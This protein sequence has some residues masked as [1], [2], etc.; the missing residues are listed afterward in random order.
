MRIGDAAH[1]A[2]SRNGL[3]G[4]RCVRAISDRD[5]HRPARE[6]WTTCLWPGR[7]AHQHR[8]HERPGTYPIKVCRSEARIWRASTERRRPAGIAVELRVHERRE[9]LDEV[10]A[11]QQSVLSTA[12]DCVHS[13]ATLSNGHAAWC[14]A[15]VRVR[16]TEACHGFFMVRPRGVT[17]RYHGGYSG[18]PRWNHLLVDRCPFRHARRVATRVKMQSPFDE[19]RPRG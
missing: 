19:A 4:P 10:G 12:L 9:S 13:S 16:A 11:R 14:Y 1:H 8:R 6:W 5:R 3:G 18:G 15:P 17:S 7:F 2:R